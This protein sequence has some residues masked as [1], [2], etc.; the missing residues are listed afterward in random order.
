MSVTTIC[1]LMPYT[2]SA[3][4]PRSPCDCTIKALVLYKSG[5]TTEYSLR[6]SVIPKEAL[7]RLV[8]DKPSFSKTMTDCMTCFYVRQLRWYHKNVPCILSVLKF[9]EVCPLLCGKSL[10]QNPSRYTP[11]NKGSVRPVLTSQQG[12]S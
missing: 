9:A 5:K 6:I 2:I 3:Q 7:T 8:P 12:T 10:N 1:P 4:T 11:P